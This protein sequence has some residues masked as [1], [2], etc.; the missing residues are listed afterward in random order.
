MRTRGKTTKPNKTT[1]DFLLE[2]HNIIIKSTHKHHSIE[3]RTHKSCKHWVEKR[4]STGYKKR[5]QKRKTEK[6]T[7]KNMKKR[8]RL[9]PCALVRSHNW[10]MGFFPFVFFFAS[11]SLLLSFFLSF[12]AS[13]FFLLDVSFILHF[14]LS[15]PAHNPPTH[16][17]PSPLPLPLPIPLNPPLDLFP[18]SLIVCSRALSSIWAHSEIYHK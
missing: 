17:H 12:F 3:A 13:F 4:Q 8:P 1:R 18:S 6:K 2:K 14:P 15:S 9:A 5:K 10:W 16:S 7:K 11:F